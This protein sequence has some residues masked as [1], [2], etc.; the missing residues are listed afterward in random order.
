MILTLTP[1]PTIDRVILCR[2]FSLGTVVRAEGEAITPCGKG[3]AASVVIHELGGD[4]V[5][6]GLRAGIT[7][8]LHAALL[9]GLGVEHD[10][11][12]A[13]G[14]TRTM[15]VLV[16]LAVHQQSSISAPTLQATGAHLSELIARLEANAGGAWG[17]ICGGSLPPGLPVDSYAQLLRWARQ[18]G[19]VTLL[20]SSGEALRRGVG[21]LPHILKVNR[22]EL[23][24]LDPGAPADL[25]ELVAVMVPRLGSWATEALIVTLGEQ[26]T[27]AVTSAGSYRALPPR[28]PVVNTAGAGDALAGGMM[29][30]RS[31]GS[32]WPAALALGTAA[33][34]SVVMNEG[35]ATSRRTE[36]EELLPRVR[37]EELTLGWVAD[38]LGL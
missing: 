34:A 1:N 10:L 37:V 3:V 31:R 24:E 32:D 28:V 5:A 4:T 8:D 14:E 35:T 2:N 36:V 21:G 15:V 29:L 18:R 17:L 23:V 13:Q 12:P 26:G 16:D 7:G 19:L 20:D 25:D 38:E 6:L 11:V 27:I 9:D 33:G 30:A 22:R